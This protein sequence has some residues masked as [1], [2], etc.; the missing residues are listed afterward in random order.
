MGRCRG[1]A[2]RAALPAPRAK[3]QGHS[4]G[5]R[6]LISPPPPPPRFPSPRTV[7]AAFLSV[8]G[9]GTR[10]RAGLG[11]GAARAARRAV[12]CRWQARRAR[13]CQAPRPPGARGGGRGGRRDRRREGCGVPGGVLPAK[14]PVRG[15]G[16][17][18]Q[19]RGA[20]KYCEIWRR[21]AGRKAEKKPGLLRE[22]QE[23][24]SCW[25]PH[26][27]HCGSGRWQWDLQCERPQREKVRNTCTLLR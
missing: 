9:G 6:A 18:L 16:G 17:W 20:K 8:C 23:P 12:P 21:W 22:R 11:R 10:A 7:C 1:A 19:A 4:T 2:A 27:T 15:R 26:S 14:V 24:A 25:D 5:Y 3:T 13:Y